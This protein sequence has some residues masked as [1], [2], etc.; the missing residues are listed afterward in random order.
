MIERRLVA[1]EEGLVGGHGLD[2]FRNQRLGGSRLH[3]LNELADARKASLARER[4]QPAL[5]QI[6]LVG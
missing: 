4:H 5:D 6:L 3:L 1:E 2:H